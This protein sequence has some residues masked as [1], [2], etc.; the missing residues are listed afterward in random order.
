VKRSR[1]GLA[2]CFLVAL[3]CDAHVHP[4]E[5]PPE[6]ETIVVTQWTP[7]T[8]LFMEYPAL[9]AGET[10]RAAIHVTDLDGF[11]PVTEGEG[12]IV[13][14]GESGEAQRFSGPVSRPGI[15]GV[16]I[17]P[18]RPGRYTMTLLVET[19][20][21]RDEHRIGPVTVHPA[22]EWPEVG[23]AEEDGGISFLKEQQWTL[24]FAVDE[25]MTRSLRGGLA[26]SAEVRPRT[27]G[28]AK[29]TAPV[30]G[31][32]DPAGSIPPVGSS[33][34]KGD[35]L[36]RLLPR[37]GVSDRHGN[38]PSGWSRRRRCLNGASPRRTP[39]RP[40]RRPVSSWHRPDSNRT[41]RSGRPT[42]RCRRIGSSPCAHR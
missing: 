28:E 29:M 7:R 35:V 37:S 15:F 16:D 32:I 14:E 3:G 11:S 10:S 17:V 21:L 42:E 8:E 4:V 30:A 12:T 13:L 34:R 26:L 40:P 5:S 18:D 39:P 31:R 23:D 38:G 6:P 20:T 33:I 2:A 22:G 19:P 36:A 24:D 9:A 25:V 41:I 1:L 27:A